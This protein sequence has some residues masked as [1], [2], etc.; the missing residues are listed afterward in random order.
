MLRL[1]ALVPAL[2]LTLASSAGA[3]DP[4]FTPV[5][6]TFCGWRDYETG[7][8]TKDDPAPGTWERL[9]ARDM[10]CRSARRNYGRLRVTQTPPYRVVKAGYRCLTLDSDT[11]YGDVRCS[12]HGR[13]RVAFRVQS[14]S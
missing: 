9:F 14:A 11:E 12:K 6:Y 2:V 10:S 3:Q 1:L 13:A 4:D 8:W 5:G 7:R